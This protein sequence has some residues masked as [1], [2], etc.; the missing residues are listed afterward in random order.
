MR[1]NIEDLK[2]LAI[3]ICQKFDVKK[4]VSPIILVF[5]VDNMN[6]YLQV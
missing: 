2:L 4:G 1:T 5:I 6:K 3:S